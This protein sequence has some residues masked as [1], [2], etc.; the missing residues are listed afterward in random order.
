MRN[1]YNIFVDKPEGKRP[2]GASR[3]TEKDDI[4]LDL[5]ANGREIV[6]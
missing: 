3:H 5:W 6:D 1:G 4:T 2:F